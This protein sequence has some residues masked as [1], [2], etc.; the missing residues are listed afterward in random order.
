MTEIQ[1]KLHFR[2]GFRIYYFEFICY[3]YLV[4]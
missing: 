2:L 1:N 3:L 4:I